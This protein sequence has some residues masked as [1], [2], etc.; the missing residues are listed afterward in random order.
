M[1]RIYLPQQKKIRDFL[2][3]GFFFFSGFE[4]VFSQ[5]SSHFVTVWDGQNGQNHMN[6]FVS[7]ALL[8][9]LQIGVN[10]EIAVFS[11]SLCVGATKLTQSINPASSLTFVQIRASQDDG[12]LNG[13][14]ENDTIIFKIW[15][16]KNLKEMPVKTAKFK[17]DISTWN[18]TGRYAMGSTSV[19]EITSFT[20]YTQVI[21]LLKGTNLFSTY[22]TPANSNLTTVLKALCDQKALISVQDELGKT[23][24]YSTTTG[25]WVNNIGSLTQTEGYS[26]SLNFDSQLQLTGRPVVLPLAIPLKKGWNIISYPRM[27]AVN[28]LSI[29]QPLIDLKIL[30]KVQDEKG[31][32]IE[33]PKGSSTFRN[34]IGNFLPG[35]AYKIYMSAAGTLTIQKT[36]LKSAPTPLWADNTVFFVPCFTSNGS[37]HMNLHLSNLMGAGFVEGD[38]LAAFDGENCVGALKLNATHFQNNL[39]SIVATSTNEIT[40]E[41]GFIS[42]NPI[43]IYSWN[44]LE[45]TK[46]TLSYDFIDGEKQFEKNASSIIQL[47]SITTS[48]AS[49]QNSVEFKV[50]PNPARLSCTVFLSGLPENGGTISISDISGRKIETRH[51]QALAEQFD[52]SHLSAGIYFVRTVIGEK[53]EIQKLIIN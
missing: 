35:K 38:E 25:S 36:Y 52:L 50:F 23:F 6:I 32:T 39:A 11:K 51:V 17:S 19:A 40:V 27:D 15:D 44:M 5:V 43:Q 26:I 31:N 13:F 12:T 45:G 8:E 49:L 46:S 21:P 16:S 34:N 2:I 20:E 37:D 10:D 3:L 29:V 14:A 18:S 41:N 1:T 48:S 30:T 4:P 9:G 53:T 28:G 7:S 24:S 33:K 42:G 22:V 47:K